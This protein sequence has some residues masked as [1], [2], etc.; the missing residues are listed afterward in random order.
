MGRRG[1][2]IYRRSLP[3]RTRH[4]LYLIRYFRRESSGLTKLARLGPARAW[5]S[6][7]RLLMCFKVAFPVGAVRRAPIPVWISA[8]GRVFVSHWCDLLVL[9]EI[10]SPPGD[11]DFAE[12]PESPRT[13]VDLGAN[14]GFSAR[15]L[16]ERYPYAELVA[17]EPDPEIFHLAQRNVRGHARVSLQ[18]RAVA[19]EPGPLELHRFA[20]G[21]WGTSSF[22][23]SQAVTESFTADAVT[24]DS[25]ISEL[26]DVDLLKIDIEG[27]EYEVLKGCQQLDRVRCIVGEF[28]TIPDVTAEQFFALLDAYDIL[29]DNVR[30]GQGTFLVSR[31]RD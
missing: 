17:Y 2:A 11:Y 16:S 10:Y 7:V 8:T 27:A 3:S 22:V 31:R 26:G 23:T 12:L 4:W 20:G 24:L 1:Q 19:G 6:F 13:I 9:G 30:E 29:E 15:F 25:I 5:L 18:N 14:V 21:S 28:H